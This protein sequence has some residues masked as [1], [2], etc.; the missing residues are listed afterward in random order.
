[1]KTYL[2]IITP[3][4]DTVPSKRLFDLQKVKGEEGIC[5]DFSF[6]LIVSRTERLTSEMFSNLMGA[7]ITVEINNLNP[8]GKIRHRY[9]CGI[10]N[11]I[12]EVGTECMV[13]QSTIWRY[14]IELR[15]CLNALKHVR[16]CRVFQQAGNNTMK[17]V[18]AVLRENGVHHISDKTRGGHPRR[19]Y[20]TLY[21]E[22]LFDFVVRLTAEDGIIWR[23]EHHKD[24]HILVFEKST[25]FLPLLSHESIPTQDKVTRFF[26]Q[27]NLQPVGECRTA[28]FDWQNPMVKTVTKPTRPA[29]EGLRYFKYPGNFIERNN[30]DQKMV[31]LGQAFKSEETVYQGTSSRRDFIAGHRFTLNAQTLPNLNDKKFILKTL[32]IE[33]TL[34]Q[35]TNEFTCL[36]DLTPFFLKPEEI[37]P[38]PKIAGNQ[39]ATVVGEAGASKV[40]TDE[41]GQVPVKF[42]WDYRDP[43]STQT[44]AMV[45]NMYPAAGSNRGFI[46]IPQVGDEVMVSFED[47]DPDRPIIVGRVYS[48]KT[49]PPIAQDAKPAQSIIKPNIQSGSN[50]FVFDDAQGK[51]NIKILAKNNMNINVDGA[52]DMDVEGDLV[53]IA[54]NVDITATGNIITGNIFTM[55]GTF[56]TSMA[57]KTI[58]NTVLVIDANVA[59]GLQA[60]LAGGA[61]ANIALGMVDSGS[62]GNMSFKGASIFNSTIGDLENTGQSGVKTKSLIVLNTA[63]DI[64]ENSSGGNIKSKALFISTKSE[65]EK[66]TLQDGVKTQALMVKIKGDMVINK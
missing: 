43:N 45:R 25:N 36:P 12:R 32:K 53:M 57:L 16:D 64:I 30:G 49:Y 9:I 50:Q 13:L 22:T 2:S 54:T 59:G 14:E 4:D 65:N 35:Y 52:M 7:Q 28:S 10:V 29:S 11:T 55:A 27:G 60:N 23:F 63:S 44:A 3:L 56:I 5:K 17:I 41:F 66:N 37:P 47:G 19:D 48:G 58:S 21:N 8:K 18:S 61:Y 40:I 33:A 26:K 39:S 6:Q 1:M 46:F 62:G 24:H 51:E 15:S 38:K 31:R 20:V 34:N 42:H